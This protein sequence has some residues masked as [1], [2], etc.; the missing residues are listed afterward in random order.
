QIGPGLLKTS[1]VIIADLAATQRFKIHQSKVPSR[2][3]HHDIQSEQSPI[4]FDA[5]PEETP[6]IHEYPDRG[7]VEISK[8]PSH[9][10]GHPS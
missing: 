10:F 9:G 2:T 7:G 3:E 6:A 1:Q 4:G 8:Q 5:E